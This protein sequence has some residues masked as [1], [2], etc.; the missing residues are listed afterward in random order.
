MADRPPSQPHRD[1]FQEHEQVFY[2]EVMSRMRASSGR[3][4]APVEEYLPIG[5]YYGALLNSPKMTALASRMGTYFRGVGNNDG[6]YTHADREF[7][8]QVLANEF[9][10]NV[11][12]D[13]HVFD[14]VKSGVRIEAIE[15]LREGRVEDLNDHEKLLDKYI[16]QV[17]NGIV[18]DE[19]YAS[20]EDKLGVRGLVEY[21]GFILWLQ[22]VMRMMQ[23]LRTPELDDD[24]VDR[25]ILKARRVSVE[26]SWRGGVGGWTPD[27]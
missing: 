6:S 2:D 14:A 1:I 5:A 19:T 9:K 27:S 23:A 17:V 20:I 10:S 16:R 13:V 11:V 18:D 24:A 3:T 4:E 26:E 15:A 8:D 25:L 21:T 12:M 22:W 7:V